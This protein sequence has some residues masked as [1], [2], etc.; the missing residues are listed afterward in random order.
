[1][2]N[3]V[4]MI[5]ANGRIV[6]IEKFEEYEAAD[7]SGLFAICKWTDK[8]GKFPKTLIRGQQYKLFY[9]VGDFQ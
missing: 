1:M 7:G 6:L 5:K 9:R 8:K 4:Y 2:S 3:G